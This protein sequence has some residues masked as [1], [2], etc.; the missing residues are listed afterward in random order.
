VLF[1]EEQ[2]FNKRQEM[3][4]A[5]KSEDM[6]MHAYETVCDRCSLLEVLPLTLD[7]C[8]SE[9][10]LCFQKD[11]PPSFLSLAWWGEGVLQGK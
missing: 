9:T 11:P 7:L 6:Y 8:D 10:C 2:N 1:S 4:K 5:H 3:T